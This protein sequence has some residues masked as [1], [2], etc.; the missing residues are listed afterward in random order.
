MKTRAKTDAEN[1]GVHSK[2]EEVLPGPKKEGASS[3]LEPG[4]TEEGVH[5][6]RPSAGPS[7]S[8][9]ER[10]ASLEAIFSRLQ[11]FGGPNF[12][13]QAIPGWEGPEG[14]QVP[15][16]S[17]SQPWTGPEVRDQAYGT[18]PREIRRAEGPRPGPVLLQRHVP[19]GGS[20]GLIMGKVEVYKGKL[21]DV[22]DIHAVVKH[23]E[24]FENHQR[25]HGDETQCFATTLTSKALFDLRLWGQKIDVL[26]LLE[27]K[28][29]LSGHLRANRSH[30]EDSLAALEQV[31]LEGYMRNTQDT[32]E[33]HVGNCTAVLR[34]AYRL[35]AYR[36]EIQRLNGVDTNAAKSEPSLVIGGGPSTVY[37]IFA[38]KVKQHVE[39]F[40]P[41]CIEGIRFRQMVSWQAIH[42]DITHNIQKAQ[43]VYHAHRRMFKAYESLARGS[44]KKEATHA[45]DA[46]YAAAKSRIYAAGDNHRKLFNV[47]PQKFNGAT[48]A[49]TA[50]HAM[51]QGE[52]EQDSQDSSPYFTP[53][54]A[55]QEARR[56]NM[57]SY[58]PAEP[59]TAGDSE[60]DDELQEQIAQLM[61]PS[62]QTRTY[63]TARVQEGQR[64]GAC[65]HNLLGNCSK[66]AQCPH[67]HTK[68]DAQE[69]MRVVAANIESKKWLPQGLTGQ[70]SAISGDRPP[71]CAMRVNV[72]C[73]G[74]EAIALIDTGN[75]LPT[76]LAERFVKDHNIATYEI[77]P[78]KVDLAGTG[79]KQVI[80]RGADVCI[81]M[82]SPITQAKVEATLQVCVFPTHRDD[83]I[84]GLRDI[85]THFIPLT[86]EL[87]LTVAADKRTSEL[88][89]ALSG[90]AGDIYAL[91]A[92]EA[93]PSRDEQ[94][95]AQPITYEEP[96]ANQEADR[97]S[98]VQQAD[99]LRTDSETDS[100]EE[101]PDLR[102][103]REN[104]EEAIAM[105]T[106][107]DI[108][109][110]VPLKQFGAMQRLAREELEKEDYADMPTLRQ[111]GGDPA[112]VSSHEEPQRYWSETVM[113]NE[114]DDVPNLL[115]VHPVRPTRPLP[116]G[117]WRPAT[118][119]DG[120]PWPLTGTRIAALLQEQPAKKR[121]LPINAPK[122]AGGGDDQEPRA[123]EDG[124]KPVRGQLY[125]PIETYQRA[126][127]ED[128]LA[129]QGIFSEK[130][131]DSL[132]E[133]YASNEAYAQRVHE[134]REQ[135]KTKIT[136]GMGTEG[137]Q[138]LEYLMMDEGDAQ[139]AF[140]HRVWR[141]LKM[142]PVHIQFMD[143]LPS[144]VY[145]K[146]RPVPVHLL[147]MVKE[148]I[149]KFVA[150]GYLVY[151]NYGNYASPTL[152]VLKSDGKSLRMCNDLRRMNAFIKYSPVPQPHVHAMLTMLQ[153]FNLFSELDWTT[154]YHQIPLDEATQERLAM[155]TPFGI[156]RPRF[157]PEG[158]S[159][160]SALMMGAVYEFFAEYMEWLVPI[161]DNLLIAAYDSKDM[162]EKIKII[163]RRCAEVG[164][165][166]NIKKSQFGVT[167]LKFFGYVVEP[168]SYAIDKDRIED[169]LQIPFPRNRKETQRYLG[170]AVFCSPFI[171]N[172][173]QAFTR[174][175]E[176]SN[177]GFSFERTQWR[178]IDYEAEFEK[179][180]QQVQ[181]AA[182]VH[183]PDRSLEW[184]LRTDASNVA[185][186]GVLLQMMPMDTLTVQ[187]REQ[188]QAQNLVRD[189]DTV[190]MPI[191]FVSKKLSDAATR[192][193]VT[194]QELYAIVH[195]LKKLE[196]LVTGKLL[197]I[198]TD[199]L[200]LVALSTGTIATSARC[201]RWRQFLAQFQY[202]IRHIAGVRNIQADYLSRFSIDSETVTPALTAL[203]QAED[204]PLAAG[205][206]PSIAAM[207]PQSV[208]EII[209]SVHNGRT[210]HRGV[211][212]TWN[213]VRRLYPNAKVPIKSVERFV[214]DCGICAKL[215][216]P[217]REAQDLVKAL[218]IYHARA[219]THVD[220][221]MLTED[222]H[223][224]KYIFVFINAMT[225]YTLLYPSKDK[226]AKSAAGALMQ[227]AA[228]VGL[229]DMLWSDN[230]PEFC[231]EV[232]QEMA[233]IVG[234]AWTFTLAYRPQANG[235]VERQ[236][237]EILE[238]VRVLLLFKDTWRAWSEPHVIS[239][240]QLTLNTRVHGATGYAPVELMFG[241]AARQYMRAPSALA[242]AE[243]AD[244][245]D[246]NEA[247]TNVQ[248]A[249]KLN[250]IASQLPRLRDQPTVALAF[251]KGDLVLRNPR[252]D[253]G[254]V[255]LRKSKL[256]PTNLGP[257][258]VLEQ[259]A[260]PDATRSN[261]VKVREVN[262][263]TK[264]HEFHTSTLRM[265]VGG[266][267]L[268]KELAK[269][270]DQEYTIIRVIN[271]QGNTARR[272]T[273]VVLM[274]LEDNSIEEMP[275]DIAMHTAA[276]TQ[277]CEGITIG[278]SL[279]M[280][281]AEQSQ[282]VR[283]QSPRAQQ[284]IT[285]LM[286]TWPI[287]ERI[288]VGE[289][290]YITAHYW[291][292]PTWH[293]YQDST[294]LPP[295]ARNR[296]PM[297]LAIVVKVTKKT[298]DLDI[299]GLA[300]M[301]SR[302]KHFVIAMTLPKVLLYTTR[303]QNM[304]SG[305]FVLTHELLAKCT[306]AAELQEA[307]SL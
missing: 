14:E 12:G 306:L 47:T 198:E 79:N 296:E 130:I 41:I 106:E 214:Q 189:N 131:I 240:V 158:V 223:G 40:L 216:D 174:V 260:G 148:L 133:A 243:N 91:Q 259:Y 144:S 235:V 294:T 159:V 128:E 4:R 171:V 52:E 196:H 279:A 136:Q 307:A 57:G 176:M 100:E 87:L 252:R 19:P 226:E 282:Y 218:P 113:L 119:D 150:Q 173:V 172:F 111:L 25:V 13:P 220:V 68:A 191:A 206:G 276:F 280:T 250:L 51:Q 134:F 247:L 186:G 277:Y 168:G 244:L 248:E 56:L 63:D 139:D 208:L 24:E 272:D 212:Q 290:R 27:W 183:F 123:L 179:S 138:L 167:R 249:A 48:R 190:A 304:R 265:F 142:M 203:Q 97:L 164:V 125:T 275:Y 239:L 165:Q 209:R 26:T 90:L 23:L 43:E 11:G 285:Q 28:N 284:S 8:A 37:E 33:Y 205:A 256:E 17:P 61:Q 210:G 288:A 302:L 238:R 175:Y 147:P 81:T 132:A 114:E 3:N 177:A 224:M 200:N 122:A 289:R 161:H 120:E 297:L 193:T 88:G 42:R 2:E 305:S 45:K 74:H 75:E 6:G 20:Y 163:L 262:N 65:F 222:K 141:G 195:C 241:T 135:C 264:T 151:S 291:N 299:P 170:L 278:R 271:L 107:E 18:M 180:K 55:E 16:F 32:R 84:V 50:V 94:R 268:A 93:D 204:Q 246:F 292:S 59:R 182:A 234:S 236:N 76:C 300:R 261:S 77:P 105:D 89:D 121:R 102:P 112:E 298:V 53:E 230:G 35:E 149:D 169:L 286:D 72:R 145:Q 233:K 194:E 213:E 251:E 129:E 15:P 185:I 229:T 227:H 117:P 109:G 242:R 9:E 67:S 253:T 199:H 64:R 153:G 71:G 95:V 118:D 98:R 5:T 140:T 231:A 80:N 293:I 202:I 104:H 49:S 245:M 225:K 237:K 269:L 39:D 30:L 152:Y 46:A 78:I 215:R 62:G 124:E 157:L 70:L 103:L 219:V 160:G 69:L 34:Y 116:Y 115:P 181:M 1:S 86:G 83:M 44:G 287:E 58:A 143:T 221:L 137:Q 187:Q 85:I 283:E 146:A 201:V 270:D 263:S 232:T 192:W 258:E 92:Q 66:G 188:A 211:T 257:Y 73:A 255:G 21:D 301:G 295:E 22:M 82:I 178:D 303:E 127:E 254:S 228:V 54:S 154:A 156:Y 207:Q 126:P 197:I 217:P 36:E 101:M 267:E 273:L 7:P 38:A 281:R 29:I 10:L 96:V 162:L 155:N 108:P 31:P 60:E 110:L 166:L 274:E 184:V 266:M 99:L